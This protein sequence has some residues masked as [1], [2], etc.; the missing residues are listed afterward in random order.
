ML[1]SGGEP[2]MHS[3]FWAL[4]K[5]L[6]AAEIGITI[7]STGILLRRDAERLV[8]YCDDVIV[9]L[10]GPREVHNR[11]RNLPR[12][13][14]KLAEGILAVHEAS[15][16]VQIKG[17]CTVQRE[18]FRAM[19]ET[20]AAAHEL[21]LGGI[22]F[23]AAT[24]VACPSGMRRDEKV[25]DLTNRMKQFAYPSCVLLALAFIL[26]NFAVWNL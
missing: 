21:G 9:S 7:V 13:Y 16:G 26:I 23:L 6:Q 10:D 8:H 20:V 15:R 14:E 24:G 5:I 1:L 2:L 3:D 18:N 4:C 17:R 11:I 25:S 19:R 12:A 22:S